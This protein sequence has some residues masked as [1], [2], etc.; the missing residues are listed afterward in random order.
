AL[1]QAAIPTDLAVS[2]HT[3]P[4]SQN[5]RAVPTARRITGRIP[6]PGVGVASAVGHQRHTLRTDSDM[7]LE[8]HRFIKDGGEA[9]A[10]ARLNGM[11]SSNSPLPSPGASAQVPPLDSDSALCGGGADADSET[12]SEGIGA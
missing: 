10:G 12:G 3:R 11:A 5:K 7:V 2:V 6:R 1:A 4:L 9:P 8:P